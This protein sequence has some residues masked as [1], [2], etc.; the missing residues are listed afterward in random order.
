MGCNKNK[1]ANSCLE[2]TNAV[3]VKYET[4][5]PEWSE[6]NDCYVSLEDTTEE[7]YDVVGDL[8]ESLDSSNLKS[9]CLDVKDKKQFEI[10]QEFINAICEIKDTMLDR[11]G[12]FNLCDLDYGDL[13]EEGPCD[14]NRPT[15]ICEFAQFVLNTL[16]ELKN[17]Q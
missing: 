1:T 13:L 16:K 11:G 4:D 15:T 2:K 10:N 12:D 14:I 6:I 17:V 7:L 3:C 9:E 5:L 8:K